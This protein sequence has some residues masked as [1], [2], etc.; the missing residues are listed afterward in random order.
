MAGKLS[1]LDLSVNPKNQSFQDCQSRIDWYS[2]FS[3]NQSIVTKERQLAVTPM[4]K[5]RKW[6]NTKDCQS[7]VT[8]HNRWSVRLVVLVG[9]WLVLNRWSIN[10]CTFSGLSTAA[11]NLR[12][13]QGKSWRSVDRS[14]RRIVRNQP[15]ATTVEQAMWFNSLKK[16]NRIQESI[17]PYKQKI[18]AVVDSIG[19]SWLVVNGQA[20]NRHNIIVAIDINFL[21]FGAAS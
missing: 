5:R 12:F 11:V 3:V 16:V 6:R 14:L 15:L 8:R 20:I 10:D 7:M 13:G 21:C 2:R 4:M 19:S 17:S 9:K 18:N 1:I